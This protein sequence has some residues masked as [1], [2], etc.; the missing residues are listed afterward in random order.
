MY[1]IVVSLHAYH[2][3]DP[4]CNLREEENLQS[5]DRKPLLLTLRGVNLQILLCRLQLPVA[6]LQGSSGSCGGTEF[7]GLQ[8]SRSAEAAICIWDLQSVILQIR[9]QVC[10]NKNLQSAGLQPSDGVTRR[11]ARPS[12]HGAPPSGRVRLCRRAPRTPHQPR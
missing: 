9:L 5:A 7:P 8:L 2:L 12:E 10:R 6:A 11:F 1:G 3:A 4:I